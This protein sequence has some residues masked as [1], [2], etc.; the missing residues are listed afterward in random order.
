MIEEKYQKIKSLVNV[1]NE[2][3]ISNEIET[4]VVMNALFHCL[5]NG[6]DLLGLTKEEFI[7]RCRIH[8]QDMRND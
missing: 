1:I 5:I 8:C 7:Q 3:L 4:D 6:A 2:Y